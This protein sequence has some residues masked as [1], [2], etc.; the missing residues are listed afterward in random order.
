MADRFDIT[1][2]ERLQVVEDTP[3]VL[4]VE[5]YFAPRGNRPPAHYHPR[6]DEHFEVL[7]GSLR[8]QYRK[9]TLTRTAQ[10]SSPGARIMDETGADATC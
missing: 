5:A 8:V 10:P 2:G 6:Q 9:P 4:T 3:E 7:E 1:A